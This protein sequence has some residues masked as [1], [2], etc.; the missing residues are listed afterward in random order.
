MFG[1]IK[2]S[3]LSFSDW[4]D[5]SLNGVVGNLIPVETSDPVEMNCMKHSRRF[6][7][8]R[9]SKWWRHKKGLMCPMRYFPSFVEVTNL[10]TAH[11]KKVTFYFS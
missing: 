9:T 11:M 1:G 10:C 6:E 5:C 2:T 8:S 4:T 7:C 3:S